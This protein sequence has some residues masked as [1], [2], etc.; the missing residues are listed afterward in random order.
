MQRARRI[1]IG[2]VLALAGILL[3]GC[4]A[5]DTGG[6]TVAEA[7]ASGAA[8]ATSNDV[9]SPADEQGSITRVDY[10]SEYDG[11]AIEKHAL[12]YAPAG[13]DQDG[14]DRYDIVYLMHGAG[15]NA[16]SWLDRTGDGPTRLQ[17]LLDH[18]I[19]D[20]Q[21]DPVIV[22]TPTFYPDDDSSMDLHYAGELDRQF[23][24]ELE[25]DLMP[26][27][28][29]RFR[30]YATTADTEGFRASRDHRAFGGFSMGG[31][32]TWYTFINNLD[33][34]R[35]FMP[36]AG[37]SWQVTDSGGVIEPE[38]TAANLDRV[39][40]D[41]GYSKDDYLILASVGGDDGTIGQMQPQIREMRTY[42]DS[43]DDTNL[44][45]TID[46]GGGHDDDSFLRQL[47]TSIQQIF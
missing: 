8:R 16:D 13:Y 24:V 6:R 4:T 35:Y 29:S 34:F 3:A 12:V 37:D 26:A 25:D 46:E 18:M 2:S 22:V 20:G 45:F 36:M 19:E 40:R 41:S 28:E 31:V 11:D 23:H 47:H 9:D 27:V 44:R 7:T 5:A 1:T 33:T 32:T 15:G 17:N 30:T 39:A 14:T 42:P 21:I 43:F 10:P 38:R